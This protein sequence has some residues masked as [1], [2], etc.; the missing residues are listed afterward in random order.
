[1]SFSLPDQARLDLHARGNALL[2]QLELMRG[3]AKQ[4]GEIESL[5]AE[6]QLALR[7]S[8]DLLLANLDALRQEL[9]T[10][11]PRNR[12][13]V[14][15]SI[16]A[17]VAGLMACSS[18]CVGYHAVRNREMIGKHDQLAADSSAVVQVEAEAGDPLAAP[19]APV[20]EP[21]SGLLLLS[22]AMLFLRRRRSS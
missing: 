15:V 10:P 21:T 4:R 8:G 12:R 9:V 6:A 2:R 19:I 20:P 22:G 16:A 7:R 18:F 17:C 13:F 14:W 1:M 5:D 3:V 11:V